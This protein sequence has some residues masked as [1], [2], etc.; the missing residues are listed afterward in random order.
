MTAVIGET[1]TFT[2]TITNTGGS[3]GYYQGYASYE[4]QY[5]QY[6]VLILSL[7]TYTFTQSITVAVPVSRFNSSCGEYI[8]I[9]AT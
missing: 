7:E 5:F 4:G 1:I 9:E 8:D 2:W 3:A 6:N